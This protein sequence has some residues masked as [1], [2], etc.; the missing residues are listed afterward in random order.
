MI[1]YCQQYDDFDSISATIKSEHIVVLRWKDPLNAIP[2]KKCRLLNC[3][4]AK[5]VTLYGICKIWVYFYPS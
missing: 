1:I 4:L 2:S 3:N 5:Y